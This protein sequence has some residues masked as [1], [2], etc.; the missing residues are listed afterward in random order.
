MVEAQLEFQRTF[1]TCDQHLDMGELDSKQQTAYSKQEVVNSKQQTSSSKQQA[2]PSKQQAANSQQ[3][4]ARSR[5]QATHRKHFGLFWL[6][7]QNDIADQTTAR[8]VYACGTQ[9]FPTSIHSAEV[10]DAGSDG[11]RSF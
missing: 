4:A 10:L 3:Q 9:F 5:R 2:A 8:R 7:L 1:D 6:A 11:T